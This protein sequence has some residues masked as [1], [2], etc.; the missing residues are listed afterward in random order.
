MYALREIIGHIKASNQDSV[1][2]VL[3]CYALQEHKM[4]T[5]TKG[6]SQLRAH[7]VSLAPCWALTDITRSIVHV[8]ACLYVYTESNLAIAAH[9]GKTSPISEHCRTPQRPQRGLGMRKGLAFKGMINRLW[10]YY[11]YVCQFSLGEMRRV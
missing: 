6:G 5:H 4:Q 3:Q 11:K 2:I 9:W 8:C 10:I 1:S 7:C